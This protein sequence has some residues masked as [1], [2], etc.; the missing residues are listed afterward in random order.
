MK[1]M[2]LGYGSTGK[3]IENYLL[4]QNISSYTIWDDYATDISPDKS[5]SNLENIN[6]GQYGSIYISPGIPPDHKV[7]SHVYLSLIH[8]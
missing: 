2:I 3:S 6:S 7:I 5:E 8:I 1:S 4:R